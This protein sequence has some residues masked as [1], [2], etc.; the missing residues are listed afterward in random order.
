MWANNKL[1]LPNPK[2]QKSIAA[3]KYRHF[4]GAT[5]VYAP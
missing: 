2:A 3:Q 4:A 1:H 5:L